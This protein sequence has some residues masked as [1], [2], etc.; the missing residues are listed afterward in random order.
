MIKFYELL[1]FNGP[2][3]FCFTFYSGMD[4][5]THTRTHEISPHNCE[6]DFEMR[7]I[8]LQSMRN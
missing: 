3:P 6:K 7:K 2:N 4:I 8:L 1:L 5:R